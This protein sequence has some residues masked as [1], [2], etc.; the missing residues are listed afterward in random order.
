MA[1]GVDR[2]ADQEMIRADVRPEAAA[3]CAN[4]RLCKELLDRITVVASALA[5]ISRTFRASHRSAGEAAFIDAA[6]Q[7]RAI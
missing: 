3:L 4:A 2:R 1:R 7:W 5:F 6:G